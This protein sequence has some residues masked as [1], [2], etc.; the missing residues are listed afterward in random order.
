MKWWGH[1]RRWGVDHDSSWGAERGKVKSQKGRL[2]S[3]ESEVEPI[4]GLYEEEERKFNER[5][6]VFGQR[7]RLKL[8]C[9]QLW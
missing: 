7:N 8:M 4:G 9:R 2:F 5:A 6:V 1:A 3:R